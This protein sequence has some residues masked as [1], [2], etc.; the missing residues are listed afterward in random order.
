LFE[1]KR[2]ELNALMNIPS[3][4]SLSRFFRRRNGGNMFSRKMEWVAEQ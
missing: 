1:R 2:Y 4:E 3:G